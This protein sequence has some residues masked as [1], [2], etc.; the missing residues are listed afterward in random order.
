VLLYEIDTTFSFLKLFEL[1][2]RD[3]ALWTS[4]W[5]FWAFIDVAANRAN[6]FLVHSVV[7][8]KL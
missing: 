4:L 6:K 3:L 7:V 2:S 8:L 1:R 5:W